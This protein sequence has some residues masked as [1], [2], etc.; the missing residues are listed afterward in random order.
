MNVL[1]SFNIRT[2]LLLLLGF[3]MAALGMLGIFSAWTIQVAA[4]QASAFID[5]EF[6]SVRA[7]SEVRSSVGNARRYEKDVFLNMGDEKET[8]RYVKLWTTEV[9]NIRTATAL[10][11]T[12]AQ[13]A[14]LAMLDAL[15]KGID[16]YEQ[17]FKGILG[18]LERG[19]LNDPWAANAAMTPLKADIRSADTSLASLADSVRERATMQRDAFSRT[20]ARAPWLVALATLVAVCISAVLAMAIVRSIL[21]PIRHLRSTANAWGQGDLTAQA[22]QLAQEAMPLDAGRL[23]GVVQVGPDLRPQR[24]QLCLPFLGNIVVGQ[25]QKLQLGGIRAGAEGFGANVT[26]GA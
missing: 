19:E 16:N 8:E 7:L 26:D 21:A 1:T 20:A 3:S 10:A 18:K 15:Q 5:V 14:E 12:L 23:Q 17:G 25:I 24:P 6:E 2:R 9:G 22:E 4:G 13:P 11:K